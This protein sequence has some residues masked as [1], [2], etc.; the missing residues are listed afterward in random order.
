[1]A[2]TFDTSAQLV[3]STAT[4]ATLSYTPGAGS[5]VLVLG[6]ALVNTT[7]RTGGA[8]TFA[9]LT[10][11]Q[12][13]TTQITGG[14][15][16][17]T[18]LWYLIDPPS[19]V[20]ANIVVPNTG[21]LNITLV[22]STY[23]AAPGLTSILDVSAQAVNAGNGSTNPTV[24]ITTTVGGCAIASIVMD[25]GGTLTAGRTLLFTGNAGTD[26]YGGQYTLQATAG[27]IAM[28]WTNATSA[29]WATNA[30]AFRETSRNNATLLGVG[31]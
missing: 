23:K 5:T 8:P 18:E 6:I 1:M 31:T 24:N 30:A 14:A 28:N 12:A 21:A 17:S 4:S 20:A 9:G 3:A 11:T 26:R 25:G 13:G 29:R 19:G 27:A 16:A 15:I 22:A 7:A 10:M 2:H